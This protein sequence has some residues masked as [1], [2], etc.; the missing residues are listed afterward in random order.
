[1]VSG[2]TAVHTGYKYVQV[3][4]LVWTVVRR[5]ISLFARNGNLVVQAVALSLI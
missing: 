5:K 3:T 4:D 2:K 1:M